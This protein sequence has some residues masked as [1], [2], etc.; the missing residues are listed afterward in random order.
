MNTIRQISVN[1]LTG[2]GSVLVRTG[3]A[4]YIVPFLLLHLGREGYGVVGL[5]AVLLGLAQAADLGLGS[6]LG[7]E[8]AEQVAR[9]DQ[10]AFNQLASTTM[11]LCVAIGAVL[12]VT[13]FFAAPAWVTFFN[14]PEALRDTSINLVRIYGCGAF[15]CSLIRPVFMGVLTS[16]F[17]YDFANNIQAASRILA[18]IMLIVLL[19]I[20]NW[21][22]YAWVGVL[23]VSEL[24]ALCALIVM[25]KRVCPEF[26]L[27]PKHIRVSRAQS[28]F[29]LG[30]QV[31]ILQLANVIA[32]KSDPLVI[33]RF[34]GP[35]GVALYSPGAR[36]S[37]TLRPLVL[38]LSDQLH[39]F[40]TRQHV[41]N[42][43][44]KQ[45]KMMLFGTKYTLFLGAL[46]STMLFAF[47]DPFCAIWLKTSLGEDYLIAAQIVRLWAVIDFLVCTASLQWPIL[48]GMKRLGVMV[49]IQAGCAVL[50][51]A[52]S[53]YLTG[54]TSIGISG[55]LWGTLLTAF[56]R[57]PLLIWYGARV[58]GLPVLLFVKQALVRPVAIGLVLTSIAVAVRSVLEPA[59]Y[60]SLFVCGL[61][62]TSVWLLLLIM[63]GLGK[64]ERL[65][66][67]QFLRGIVSRGSRASR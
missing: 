42:E 12:V 17:R 28:L 55:V 36:L 49:A 57:R 39:P 41:N 1:T 32:E 4:F 63:V 13:C 14:V 61:V 8:L 43:W 6:A 54:F 18:S 10:D 15:F 52:L 38:A 66:L 34:F 7:R 31:Y 2:W 40:A 53:V 65:V 50:N 51:I 25:A 9:K 47:A 46:S 35:L 22:L 20:T 29:R 37:A 27:N 48:L 23:L 58:C 19:Q 11:L 21:G 33:A 45:Q 5:L 60:L 26:V 30:W 62:T 16:H 24:L 3:L 59:S 56:I 44:D 67:A 64:E